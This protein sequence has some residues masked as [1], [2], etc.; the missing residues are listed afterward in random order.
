VERRHGCTNID[1][2]RLGG[3]VRTRCFRE[4]WSIVFIRCL[5]AAGVLVHTSGLEAK[6]GV[7]FA[8]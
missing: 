6:S 8:R 7:Q 5:S 3:L 4:R 2:I 1:T